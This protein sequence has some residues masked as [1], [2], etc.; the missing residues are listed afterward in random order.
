MS[1]LAP[2]V[3]TPDQRPVRPDCV[4]HQFSIKSLTSLSDRRVLKA[5]KPEVHNMVHYMDDDDVALPTHVTVRNG[6][7]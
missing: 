4:R 5:E 7:Y 3:G 2:C 6:V 1:E